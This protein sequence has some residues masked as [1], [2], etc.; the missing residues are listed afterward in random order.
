MN[1]EQMTKEIERLREENRVL[2]E[3]LAQSEFALGGFRREALLRRSIQI[4]QV[5]CDGG[6]VCVTMKDEDGH[7]YRYRATAVDTVSAF[8]VTHLEP[9]FEQPEVGYVTGWSEQPTSYSKPLWYESPEAE[10]I[11]LM[12]DAKEEL[13]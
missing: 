7:L 8:W 4:R 2:D 9:V 13:E 6:V 5:S 11:E 1:T 12:P 3:K 10:S